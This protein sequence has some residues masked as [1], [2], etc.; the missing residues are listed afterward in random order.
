MVFALRLE[1]KVLS[2]FRG[3]GASSLVCT[4]QTLRTI[5]MFERSARHCHPRAAANVLYRLLHQ[6]FRMGNQAVLFIS[7]FVSLTCGV[8]L[9]TPTAAERGIWKRR[10]LPVDCLWLVA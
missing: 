10:L 1:F 5:G 3:L 7:G 4:D 6:C 8:M 9:C 2:Q